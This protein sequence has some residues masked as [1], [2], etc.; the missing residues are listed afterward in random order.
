M[1]S[2]TAFRYWS[3][4]NTSS[5]Y[6]PTHCHYL[7]QECMRTLYPLPPRP[8]MELVQYGSLKANN[9]LFRL[10]CKLESRSFSSVCECVIDSITLQYIIFLHM[11]SH[12][13]HNRSIRS[14]YCRQSR[15][16]FNSVCPSLARYRVFSTLCSCK[17]D[18]SVLCVLHHVWNYSSS[19]GTSYLHIYVYSSDYFTQRSLRAF[20]LLNRL[21]FGSII[22]ELWW[23]WVLHTGHINCPSC[24]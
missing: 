14:Q 23:I 15:Q 8:V 12:T 5:P 7:I 1:K 6:A 10:F 2:P 3:I 9:D 4:T 11:T 22:N 21:L 19:F 24:S 13:V 16:Y 17:F 20:V 18:D